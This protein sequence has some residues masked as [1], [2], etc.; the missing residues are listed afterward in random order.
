MYASAQTITNK[1][2]IDQFGYRP[3]A[4]KTAVIRNPQTGFDVS[5]SFS[6]GSTYEVINAESQQLIYS[7]TIT[8][9]NSG[10]ENTSS[11]DKAWWFD[12]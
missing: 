9:W 11:G 7:G 10:A 6:P 3:T 4:K 5:E 12:F 8:I 2:V 1:I